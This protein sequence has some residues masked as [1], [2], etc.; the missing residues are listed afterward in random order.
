MAKPCHLTSRGVVGL[1]NV[2]IFYLENFLG[3][4][5]KLLII[6]IDFPR[7]NIKLQV[8]FSNYYQHI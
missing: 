4:L 5:R 8:I 1:S 2:I 3:G 7:P 6:F